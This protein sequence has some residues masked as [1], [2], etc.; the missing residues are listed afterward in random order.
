MKKGIAAAHYEGL[1]RCWQQG[2][3]VFSR[4][5][6]VWK[7]SLRVETYGGV[8]KLNLMMRDGWP[9]NAKLAGNHP[10][11]DHLEEELRWMQSKLFDVGGLLAVAPWQTLKN[12]PTV[13]ARDIT[14]LK[15][16]MSRCQKD[17]SLL[18]EFILPGGGKISSLLHQARTL[19]RRAER[20]CV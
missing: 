12:M 4:W 5:R 17:L 11:A 18:K 8:D 7:D 19:C 6:Q 16:L 14:R 20:L 3:N 15:K 1:C 2:E 10:S 13:T 9:F